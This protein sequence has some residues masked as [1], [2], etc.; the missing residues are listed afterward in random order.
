MRLKGVA[1]PSLHKVVGHG[2]LDSGA[3]G[4]VYGSYQW[5]SCN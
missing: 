2:I 1:P 3:L 5:P 4:G